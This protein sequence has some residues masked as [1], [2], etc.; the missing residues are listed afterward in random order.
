MENR[1]GD[2]S[3]KLLVS[4]FRF[5]RDWDNWEIH[6]QGD[7]DLVLDEHGGSRTIRLD[8]AGIKK[9]MLFASNSEDV[10]GIAHLWIG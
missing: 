5:D 1:F 2:F 9:R 6:P 8:R 10:T 4:S 7:F 3:G